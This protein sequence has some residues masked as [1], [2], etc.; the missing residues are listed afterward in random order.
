MDTNDK[1]KIGP[2]KN[3]ICTAVLTGWRDFSD[4]IN[5]KPLSHPDYIYRGQS[6]DWELKPRL[7]RINNDSNE[8]ID[9]QQLENFYRASRGRISIGKSEATDINEW[10]AIGQH[11]GLVTPLLDWTESPYVALYFAF[12]EEKKDSSEFRT[13]SAISEYHILYNSI[14]IKSDYE[15][16]KAIRNNKESHSQAKGLLEKLQDLIKYAPPKVIEIVRPISNNNPRLISQRGLFTLIPKGYSIESWIEEHFKNDNENI[17]LLK[18]KI[19]NKDREDC[20]RSLNRMNI[21][22]LSLFPDLYGASKFCNM[23]LQIKGY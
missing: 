18:I 17:I 15:V 16:A 3:G 8:T 2:V 13:I 1:W 5:T 10:W 7:Y 11:N 23:R 9:S 4:F 22:H 20:L 21:N 19:P 6:E 14:K 12:I